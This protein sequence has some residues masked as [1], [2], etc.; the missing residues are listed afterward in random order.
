V[1]V[2]GY[3]SRQAWMVSGGGGVIKNVLEK[4]RM[5]KAVLRDGILVRMRVRC[6]NR[7]FL[8]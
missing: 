7:K 2:Q 1:T 3:R 6:L 4:R 5:K 8:K